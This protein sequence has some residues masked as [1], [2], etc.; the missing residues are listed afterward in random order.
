[1]DDINFILFHFGFDRSRFQNHFHF[2]FLVFTKLVQDYC[3]WN[4]NDFLWI[5]ILS[6]LDSFSFHFI[7]RFGDHFLFPQVPWFFIFL[8][9]YKLFFFFFILFLFSLYFLFLFFFIFLLILVFSYY[10]SY[11]FL[12][13]SSL[14]PCFL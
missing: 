7:H 5:N 14:Y 11:S 8:I 2:S 3:L 4:T 1:M 12:L 6:A 10:Y 9:F 13:S